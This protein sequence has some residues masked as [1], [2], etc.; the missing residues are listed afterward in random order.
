MTH[1]SS[2]NG[3]SAQALTKKVPH[4]PKP[5][6][7]ILRKPSHTTNHKWQRMTTMK[8]AKN[9]LR[10][11]S[12]KKTSV[13]S[14][15]IKLVSSNKGSLKDK[16][17]TEKLSKNSKT[18]SSNFLFYSGPKVFLTIPIEIACKTSSNFTLKSFRIFP[19]SSPR[20]QKFLLN[21]KA[22]S[23]DSSIRR[24]TKLRKNSRKIRLTRQK[25]IK[26]TKWKKSKWCQ[27]WTGS[28]TLRIKLMQ[29]ISKWS[30]SMPLSSL[31]FKSRKKTKKF[32]SK[33]FW[34]KRNKTLYLRPKFNSMKN[35]WMKSAKK[36]NNRN[37]KKSPLLAIN[38]YKCLPLGL[39]CL[40]SMRW[41]SR[42]LTI[43]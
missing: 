14:F 12:V 42:Q 33:N 30:K 38:N 36:W 18:K 8:G 9:L 23:G 21:R 34:W 4:Q 17:S 3:H 26:S 19:Q 22:T 16:F 24:L 37:S 7:A 41:K 11:C 35:C 5:Q 40:R 32:S 6:L 39:N 1:C 2:Q 27:S 20:L 10:S 25:K 13:S 43:F 15:R 31:S 29:R 28:R